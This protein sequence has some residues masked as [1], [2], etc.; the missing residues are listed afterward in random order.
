[1]SG[2]GKGGKVRLR[3]DSGIDQ[4]DSLLPLF[5]AKSLSLSCSGPCVLR[6]VITLGSWKGW[7]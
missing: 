7:S 1:M 3:A 2:R 6:V 4:T 5:R